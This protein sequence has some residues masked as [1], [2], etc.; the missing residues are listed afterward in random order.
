MDK[1][2]TSLIIP[3]LKIAIQNK[4]IAEVK[5][6][7]EVL[8]P[9]DISNLFE[10]LKIDESLFIFHNLEQTTAIQAFE[11]LEHDEKILLLENG[12]IE[13]K[14]LIINEM[15]D[16]DRADFFQ[17]LELEDIDDYKTLLNLEEQE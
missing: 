14:K 10:S 12:N 9:V 7:S 8:H 11:L 1:G 17:D 3:D 13:F 4:D 6:L 5:N 2:T 15:S 16:D